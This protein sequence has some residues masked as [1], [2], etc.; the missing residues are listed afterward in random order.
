MKKRKVRKKR[1]WIYIAAVLLVIWSVAPVIWMFISSM[2]PSNEIIDASKLM[3]SRLTLDRYRM[4]LAGKQIEGVNR[5]A[6]SQSAVFRLALLNSTL[7][8]LVTTAFSIAIG[9]SASYAF[10]VRRTISD[11]PVWHVPHPGT[12]SGSHCHGIPGVPAY[13]TVRSA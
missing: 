8:S 7:V 1:V 3:P 5:N 13:W 9:T 2:T 4:I 12:W 11:S 10:S 6:A